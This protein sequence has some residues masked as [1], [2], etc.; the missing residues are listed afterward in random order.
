MSEFKPEMIAMM[1]ADMSHHPLFLVEMERLYEAH[2]VVIG[3]RYVAGGST[4]GWE[5]WRKALSYFGNIYARTI[6]GIPV[7]DLTAGFY[8]FD[9]NLLLRVDLEKI[10]TSGYAFQIELKNLF[11]KAGAKFKESPIVF[12]N[13]VGGESK[14]SNHFLSLMFHGAIMPSLII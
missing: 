5:V 8:L 11:W 12:E 9:A 14:I 1:D 13:R 7:N 2:S 4:V 6:T 10:S 3:S